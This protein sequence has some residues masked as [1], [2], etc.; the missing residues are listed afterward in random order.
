MT[1][2]T[3]AP[4][5]V[6]EQLRASA[7]ALGPAVEAGGLS[8]ADARHVLGVLQDAVLSLRLAM[9]PLR[10]AA[11]DAVFARRWTS[12]DADPAELT[13]D[14]RAAL[15]IARDRATDI[16]VA[17]MDA[18]NALEAFD[19]AVPRTCGRCGNRFDASDPSFDGAAEYRDSGFCRGCVDRCHESSDFAHACP[20]CDPARRSG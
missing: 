10:T 6:A 20:V 5:A 3:P 4:A 15:T 14:V 1:Y 12:A 18:R 11:D 7:R 17:L 16:A 9:D 8:A 19:G 13:A 2:T